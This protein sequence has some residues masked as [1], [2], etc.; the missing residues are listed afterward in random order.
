MGLDGTDNSSFDEVFDFVKET[1][2]YEVQ[3]TVMTPFPNAPLYSRLETE[4]RLLREDAWEYC[5]L[6]DVNYQPDGMSVS[7][8]ENGFRDLAQKIYDKDFIEE[9][10]RRFFKRQS[11]LRHLRKSNGE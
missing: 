8:L 1:G 11:E 6:F 7:E 4:G 3:I 10:R 5:T 2:L 9:R